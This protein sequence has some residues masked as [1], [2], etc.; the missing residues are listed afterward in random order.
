M[1]SW[2]WP[3]LG[4]FQQGGVLGA[5]PVVP[6]SGLVP[7]L[8]GT[9][10]QCRAARTEPRPGT[11]SPSL[12][13]LCVLLPCPC[14]S[15]FGICSPCCVLQAEQGARKR[16]LLFAGSYCGVYSHSISGF[17]GSA[18]D[19]PLSVS[20]LFVLP[21]LLGLQ[22]EPWVLRADWA[23]LQ[24]FFACS[25]FGVNIPSPGGVVLILKSRFSAELHILRAW[26]LE[27]LPVVVLVIK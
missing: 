6:G 18:P 26:G 21:S 14:S 24:R 9:Q 16:L 8:Q 11:N 7:L 4:G 3:G 2:E 17:Y 25:G 13:C 20:V 23:P 12:L 15:C 19:F 22:H 5:E 1:G 10:S 27:F